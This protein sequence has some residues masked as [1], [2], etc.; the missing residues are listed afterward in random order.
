MHHGELKYANGWSPQR[1]EAHFHARVSQKSLVGVNIYEYER[2]LIR[3]VQ[4]AN[5]CSIPH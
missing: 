1:A 5:V 4:D 3:M 2:V